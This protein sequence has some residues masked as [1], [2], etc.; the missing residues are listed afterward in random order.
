MIHKL[1]KGVTVQLEYNWKWILLFNSEQCYGCII[2]KVE[3]TAMTMVLIR[4]IY[5]SFTN[6]LCSSL[7]IHLYFVTF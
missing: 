6:L 2:V 4:A 5:T 1:H 3:A 7:Y